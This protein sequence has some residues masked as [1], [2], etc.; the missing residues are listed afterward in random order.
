VDLVSAVGLWGMDFVAVP[1]GTAP[2][3]ALALRGADPDV[4]MA[5]NDS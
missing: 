4:D 1:A 5:A 3:A 2:A